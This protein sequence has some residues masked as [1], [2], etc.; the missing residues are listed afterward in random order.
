MPTKTRAVPKKV[1]YGLNFILA[2][3]SA[4]RCSMSAASDMYPC[5]NRRFLKSWSRTFF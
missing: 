4:F 5:A 1:R 2:L 3:S